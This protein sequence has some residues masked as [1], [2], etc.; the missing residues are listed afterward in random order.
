[1]QSWIYV[2]LISHI[3]LAAAD[4]AE[5][6]EAQESQDQ[7]RAR[8][9]SIAEDIAAVAPDRGSASLLVAIAVHES[10]LARDVDLGPCAPARVKKGGCD[11]GHAMTLFQVHGFSSWPTRREAALRALKMARSSQKLCAHLPSAERLA[12]YTR[13]RCSSAEG[14]RLSRE[15]MGLVR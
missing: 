12:V 4:R 8:Y 9:E 11:G 13:G 3:S 1:M 14:R 7:R 15:I 5:Y 2:L 6:P 10:G